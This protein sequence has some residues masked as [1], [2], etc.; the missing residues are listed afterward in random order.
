[1][2]LLVIIL[3]GIFVYLTRPV[4]APTL[5]ESSKQA[6][7]NIVSNEEFVTIYEVDQSRS[8]AEFN[9]FE[10]LY[11]KPFTVIGTTQSVFGELIL[12]TKN[13]EQSNL[14]TVKIDART[15][16]T[17]SSKRDGAIA[18]IILNSEDQQNNFIVFKPTSTVAIPS[19]AKI[20]TDYNF[21]ITGMLTIS[22][23]EKQVIFDTKA[24]MNKD[25]EIVGLAVADVK[26]SDFNLKIP[27]LSFLA[28]VSDSVTLKFNFT[29]VPKNN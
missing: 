4:H 19:D 25:G 21:K 22:G 17:D 12:N 15:L 18:R 16:K 5:S 24:K 8:K 29:L 13:P 3:G 20:D 2:I 23:V 14:G 9:I 27:N 28:N 1:M 7:L 10:E 6:D 26:R 11:G